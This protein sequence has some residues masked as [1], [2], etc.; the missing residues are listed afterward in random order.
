MNASHASDE[1]CSR[2]VRRRDWC[3][4]CNGENRGPMSDETCDWRA[5]AICAE[6]LVAR[7]EL[8]VYADRPSIEN[9]TGTTWMARASAM[10]QDLQKCRNV[11]PKH[12]ARL[13]YEGEG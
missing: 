2:N 12:I 9:P 5:R 11:L 4:I 1:I 13:L 10:E 7:L 3:D 8:L 6:A